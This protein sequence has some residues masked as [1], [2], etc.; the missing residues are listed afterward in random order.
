MSLASELL[1]SSL[2]D[3]VRGGVGVLVLPNAHDLPTGLAQPSVSLSVPRDV[4][5]DL[6]APPLGVVLRPCPVER[7]PM[8]KTPVDE[9]SHARP[10][11]DK[12]RP[13]PHA[14]QG[15]LVDA[16]APAAT[17][18]LRADFQLGWRVATPRPLH[19]AADLL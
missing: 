13:A 6:R 11:E 8:P 16:V 3:P 5:L 17:E 7:T 14:R 18:Q 15:R 12:I 1:M 4:A 19:A 2:L 10:Q 9:D